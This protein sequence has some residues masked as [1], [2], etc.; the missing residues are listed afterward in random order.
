MG[1]E[2][3]ELARA[4]VTTESDQLVRDMA[5]HVGDQVHDVLKRNAMMMQTTAGAISMGVLAAIE[6]LSST[7]EF[8]RRTGD[9]PDEAKLLADAALSLFAS[10]LSD[11]G[12][13]PTPPSPYPSG[14]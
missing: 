14:D 10:E 7:V 12:L 8:A 5:G 11:R 9:D 2:T 1:S 13:A 3:Q 6:V 4:L